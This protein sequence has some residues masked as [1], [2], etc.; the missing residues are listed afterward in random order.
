MPVALLA[1]LLAACGGPT[2]ESA[3]PASALQIE[4]GPLVYV[5]MG[6]SL[7]FSGSPTFINQ[8]S[9]MLEEDFGVEV[10]RL[11]R[12]VGGQR[13]DD[14]LEQLRSNDRLREDLADA[15]V[16][17]LL[18]PN[19]EWAEPF[20]TALGVDGRDPSDCGGDD[21][22]QCLRDVIDAYKQQVD[23]IFDELTAIVDPSETLVRV[24]DFYQFHT[25]G[26]QEDFDI[27]YPYWREAQEYV[28][29]VAGQHGLPVAQVFDDFM[30]TDGAY[31]D[32]VAE[33]LVDPDGV[34][35]TAEGAERMATLV[36]DLGYELAS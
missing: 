8:Y 29:Q 12:T 6:N 4:E 19:D 1:L 33:G 13:T 35:P 10:A 2:E 11:S 21:N 15:D 26:T 25:N 18:I 5:A 34:H 16:I 22:Q 23:E 30:G 3:A 14:F 27:M 20:Q 32:L 7:T 9:A 24:H 31:V 36:H 17:T 28:E